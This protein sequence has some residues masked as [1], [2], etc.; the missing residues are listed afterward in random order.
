[1]SFG[2]ITNSARVGLRIGKT[3]PGSLEL[4]APRRIAPQ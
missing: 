4:L 1:M 2:I 3:T